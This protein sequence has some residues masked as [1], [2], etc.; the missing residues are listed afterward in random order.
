MTAP[1]SGSPS[2]PRQISP[3]TMRSCAGE[4]LRKPFRGRSTVVPFALAL[5]RSRPSLATG[6]RAAWARLSLVHTSLYFNGT[7]NPGDAEG[8]RRAAARAVALAPDR[9][10]DTAHGTYY[11]AVLGDN[12]RSLAELPSPPSR[13]RQ[14]PDPHVPGES[15]SAHGQWQLGLDTCSKR[16]QRLDPRSRLAIRRY[17]DCP[18]G[19]CGAIPRRSRCSTRLAL[20]PAIPP[21]REEGDGLLAQGDLAGARSVLRQ[22][23]R[24]Q[25]SLRLSWQPWPISTTSCG[26]GRDAASVAAAAFRRARLTTDR[27]TW[28][29]VARPDIRRCEA[30]WRGRASTPTPR[31]RLHRGA[32][33]SA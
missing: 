30:T 22:R 14:R 25:S 19:A 13:P 29:I 27:G 20:A 21:D 17:A 28:G 12:V 6:V 5:L 7:P 15:E 11:V 9:A 10:W 2:G 24:R 23:S 32:P 31:D 3:P 4:E 18:A 16:N 33:R 8:A 26:A 1:S